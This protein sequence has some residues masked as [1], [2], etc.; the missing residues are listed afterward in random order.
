MDVLLE[1]KSTQL[2]EAKNVNNVILEAVNRSLPK[3]IK[4]YLQSKKNREEMLQKYGKDAFLKPDELKFPV[5]SP[6]SGEKDCRLIYAAYI[7]ANQW[8]EK[9]PEY[10][11]IAE[12]AKKMYDSEGCTNKI[13]I[14]IEDTN[15]TIPL[16]VLVQ[17]FNCCEDS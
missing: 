9:I 17:T 6:Y 3:N 5:V 7:R 10:K 13:N 8:S 11:K 14:N 4:E 15:V 2:I 12:K 1:T 16:E